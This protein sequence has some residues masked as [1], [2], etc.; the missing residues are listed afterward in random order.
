MP[1]IEITII[2]ENLT[3]VVRRYGEDEEVRVFC[4]CILGSECTDGFSSSLSLAVCLP[5]CAVFVTQLPRGEEGLPSCRYVFPALYQYCSTRLLFFF[6][7][8]EGKGLFI[9]EPELSNAR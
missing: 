5:L 9:Q 7:L 8:V 4:F 2:K 1:Q 6:L 3:D